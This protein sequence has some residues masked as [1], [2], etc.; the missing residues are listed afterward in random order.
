MEKI[1]FKINNSVSILSPK[2]IYKE[3]RYIEDEKARRKFVNDMNYQRKSL[4]IKRQ[5]R[6]VKFK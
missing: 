2:N 3:F 6:I 1:Y 4:A 5:K